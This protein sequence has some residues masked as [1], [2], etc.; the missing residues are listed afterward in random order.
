MGASSRLALSR[1]RVLAYRAG[2]HGL[3]GSGRGLAGV[4]GAGAQDNPP[5]RS[6]RLTLALRGVKAPPGSTALVHSVRGAMHLHHTGDLGGYAAAV[7]PD[8]AADVSVQS[9]GPFGSQL[10]ADGI[11]LGSVTDDVAAAMSKV[12]ADGVAR[13][14]GELSGAVTPLVDRRIAPWCDGCGVHHVHD[15]LFRF[16]TLQAELTIDVESPTLFRYVRGTVGRR[17]ARGDGRAEIVRRYLRLAG[18]VGLEHLATWLGLSTAGARRWWTLVEDDLVAVTVGP[19]TGSMLA[20]DL[21]DLRSSADPPPVRLLGPYDP[22]TALGDRELLVPDPAHRRE[23]W[24]AAANPGVLLV[25]GDV[26]GIWRQKTTGRRLILTVRPFGRFTT[27][28]RRDVGDDAQVIARHYG[29]DEVET[30]W[31]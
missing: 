2:V 1:E 3:D 28:Q 23:V 18:P 13:T 14:K 21:E 4:L 22:A 19:R 10:A 27:A 6:A 25:N 20:D 7:R 29:V 11:S 12:M 8:D 9:F 16:A 17:P 15:G 26:A 24:K 5:G 31:A 30:H